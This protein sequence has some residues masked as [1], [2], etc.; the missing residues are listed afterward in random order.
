MKTKC[1]FLIVAVALLMACKSETEEGIKYSSE[2]IK[3]AQT[4]IELPKEAATKIIT[5]DA[6]C[7]WTLTKTA[8]NWNDLTVQQDASSNT[9]SITT[10]SNP[11][12]SERIAT[13]TVT[14]KGGLKQ[15]ISIRQVPGDAYLRIDENQQQ[16]T[17]DESAGSRTL[18][19]QSN[20]TWRV[21]VSDPEWLSVSDSEMQG[22]QSV[23]ISVSKAVT[24]Q[25]R[26]GTLTF[27][28][29][30]TGVTAS[31]SVRVTQRGLSEIILQVDQ[32][33]MAFD[34][35]GGSQKLTVK[36]SNAQWL[37]MI[38]SNVKWLHADKEREI[39][40]GTIALT[41]DENIGA[42][43]RNAA[44][45]ISSG[46][47]M[48][49]V[50]VEQAAASLPI[51]SGFSLQTTGNIMETATFGLAFDSVFPVTEYGLCYSTSEHPV[52][53]GEHTS[54]SVDSKS[55]TGLTV[56]TNKLQ[57]RTRYY[58]RA[59]AKSAAGVGYSENEIEINT[60]GEV[61]E[62]GDNPPLFVLKR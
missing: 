18:Q 49:Q 9:I 31:A 60:L 35:T 13:L 26:E 41:C 29:T 48:L 58:V 11:L 23:S 39:G 62:P 32:E 30:E 54:Q 46:S 52:I 36:E 22:N 3:L 5:I 10:G 43:V 38:P 55:M 15:S 20:T 42:S 61:P 17:F 14:T 44:I 4:G 19:V 1:I 24:D 47:K 6:D 27:T 59:Y 7:D 8:D 53:I 16:M 12:R 57:P 40:T 28:S 21:T 34:C 2:L 37:V 51:V 50:S 25:E 33:A 45:T 56:T